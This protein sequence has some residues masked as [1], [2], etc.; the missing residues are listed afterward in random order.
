VLESVL[1][2]ASLDKGC[3][4]M[5][6]ASGII[7]C[8]GTQI[9]NL[10]MT[11]R[12]T[13]TH[14]EIDAH[15]HSHE[16]GD[17]SVGLKEDTAT[18]VK[19]NIETDQSVLT[20]DRNTLTN[21]KT[22]GVNV[23][24]L[25]EGDNLENDNTDARKSSTVNDRKPNFDILDIFF[26]E[27]TPKENKS[28]INNVITQKDKNYKDA[29]TINI[30]GSTVESDRPSLRGLVLNNTLEIKLFNLTNNFIEDEVGHTTIPSTVTTDIKKTDV[31]YHND[32][33]YPTTSPDAK[34][35]IAKDRSDKKGIMIESKNILDKSDIFLT[36][37]GGDESASIHSNSSIT[38]QRD[39]KEPIN[40]I[41]NLD[42]LVLQKE[43][44]LKENIPVESSN[45]LD[46][47]DIF[48][49]LLGGSRVKG[50]VDKTKATNQEENKVTKAT[51]K[52]NDLGILVLLQDSNTA[53]INKSIANNI[54]SL[55]DRNDIFNVLL[56]GTSNENSQKVEGREDEKERNFKNPK[57]IKLPTEKGVNDL[58]LL[59][60]GEVNN[61]NMKI[62]D[63]KEIN[64]D[65]KFDEASEGHVNATQV[66]N[67]NDYHAINNEMKLDILVLSKEDNIKEKVPIES[68]N[69]IDL[70]AIFLN[71]L[72]VDN[73]VTIKKDVD[74][75]KPTD[76]EEVKNTKS[77]TSQNDLDLLVLLQESNAPHINHSVTDNNVSSNDTNYF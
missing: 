1:S 48:L 11:N 21:N 60:L 50:D 34:T 13:M 70:D 65:I 53:E 5:K 59:L 36:L 3:T 57:N 44:N 37:L 49:N 2:D 42:I 33:K 63:I 18:P 76:Q 12:K 66:L 73:T 71:L 72:G 10:T 4:G 54:V 74:K 17:P 67:E 47:N 61:V 27:N 39:N 31:D 29:K 51:S 40:N 62:E 14:N 19:P 46:S 55:K 52:L 38:L 35:S 77:T 32:D 45:E 23:T 43:D 7:L 58:S 30:E 26:T 64:Y 6:N 16:A 20:N 56:S 15:L 68:N 28:G 8:T 69:E 9:R 41:T 24:G 22:K 25:A 75:S